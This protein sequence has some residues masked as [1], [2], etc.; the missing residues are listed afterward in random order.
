MP[1]RYFSCW[2]LPHIHYR[3]PALVRAHYK[4]GDSYAIYDSGC[5]NPG[6][7][8]G[9]TQRKR[10]TQSLIVRFPI[11]FH[12]LEYLHIAPGEWH[13]F[14]DK[15]QTMKVP[16][17]SF[18]MPAQPSS[19]CFYLH[20]QKKQCCTVSTHF[21]KVGQH[22][23]TQHNTARHTF[24]LTKQAVPCRTVTILFASVNTVLEVRD[25]FQSFLWQS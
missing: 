13:C 23:M 8:Q 17:V 6:W 10:T 14:L 7:R 25:L 24:T 16:N 2:A 21:C 12:M 11:D 18:W 5:R 15:W 1:Q 19:A 3:F 22:D 4:G 20:C 9:R